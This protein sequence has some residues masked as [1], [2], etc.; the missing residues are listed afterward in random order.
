M[1]SINLT[2]SL[3]ILSI[4][5]ALVLTACGP[6][7]GPNASADDGAAPAADGGAVVTTPAAQF[8]GTW[9]YES[10][11][12]LISCSDGSAEEL[13]A[14]GGTVTFTP[15]ANG[16]RVVSVSDTNCAVA[17]MI[18]GATA[19]C[20]QGTCDAGGGAIATVQSDVFTLSGGELH[21]TSTVQFTASDGSS[22]TMA[23]E[24]GVLK[25]S[26]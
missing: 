9:T 16:S 26:E 17:Y 15:G 23:L 3:S 1:R 20:D 13:Q 6:D 18:S 12:T 2:K 10:G 8:L 19:T 21:E 25:K 4:V 5:A 7:G 22:C 14:G 24:D 11:A